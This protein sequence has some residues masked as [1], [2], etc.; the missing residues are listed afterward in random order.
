MLSS[1]ACLKRGVGW[2]GNFSMGK[3]FTSLLTYSIN[4]MKYLYYKFPKLEFF[5]PFDNIYVLSF[6]FII[7]FLFLFDLVL[8]IHCHDPIFKGI[9]DKWD[10]TPNVILTYIIQNLFEYII[11]DFNMFVNLRTFI[12][13]QMSLILTYL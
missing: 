9:I 2:G 12:F 6:F 13:L 5:G 4:L 11:T 1:R 10:I 3:L 7:I 8:F